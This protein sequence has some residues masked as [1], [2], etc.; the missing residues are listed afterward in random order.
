MKYT[1]KKYPLHFAFDAR[2]SRG[3]IKTHFA[4]IIEVS[5]SHK[6]GLG[7]AS[8]LAGLSIDAVPEFEMH[9]QE[10]LMQLS[11]GKKLSSLDLVN[12]PALKFGLETAL[13]DFENG[14]LKKFEPNHWLEGNPISINGLVWMNEIPSMFEQAISKV[15]EG[16]IHI[17]F[18]VG[19]LNFDEECEML[20][21]FRK[22]F[23]AASVQIRLDANGAF[24]IAEVQYKL[25]ELSKFGIHSIEQPIQKGNWDAMA[26]TIFQS[27]IPIALDE[28]L[29]GVD[30]WSQGNNLM[31]ICKPDFLILKPT[32]IG[33]IANANE[34]IRIA[35]SFGIDWWATSALESNIGLNRIAQWCSS[36]HNALPQG[37]GTGSL[38]TNNFIA[39]F[40][41]S[42]GML[43]YDKTK[44]WQLPF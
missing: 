23:D 39:P 26:E 38:Y 44:T 34:W 25:K 4:Y 2:T 31:K 6:I 1:Y 27:P 14:G 29:I 13:Q 22:K 41:A 24:P 3:E 12:W 20:F 11:A 16:Y 42:A 9:L 15:N 19:A 37:L 18:K 7:E 36:T 30:V 33:G 17:K 21:N 8:P 40:E 5:D 35:Q 43:R 10:C 32:L 28:E